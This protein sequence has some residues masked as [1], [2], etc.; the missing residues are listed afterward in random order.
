MADLFAVRSSE[1]EEAI[2]TFSTHQANLE[3]TMQAIKSQIHNMASW[4]GDTRER[5]EE[6]M[7]QW[8]QQVAN[9]HEVLG[10]VNSDLK[11]LLEQVR[12][13]EGKA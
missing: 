11:N 2:S 7:L 6:V 4:Q 8:N 3:D 9:A 5:F 10:E 13:M 1:I 12:I